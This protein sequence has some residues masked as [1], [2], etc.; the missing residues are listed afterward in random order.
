[1]SFVH[2][3]YTILAGSAD[4]VT[5]GVRFDGI[6][7]GYRRQFLRKS[8]PPSEEAQK[9]MGFF[10][11]RREMTLGSITS[12]IIGGQNLI[13]QDVTKKQA[14]IMRFLAGAWKQRESFCWQ[15]L[16]VELIQ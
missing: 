4:F 14:A 1:M 15:G 7:Q 13:H 6:T 8:D 5:A 2:I 16:I 3:A 10:A 9:F 12:Y 11:L